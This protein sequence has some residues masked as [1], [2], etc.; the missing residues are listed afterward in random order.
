VPCLKTAEVI[1]GDIGPPRSE[2]ESMTRSL[3]E[4]IPSRKPNGCQADSLIVP[5][6]L[7]IERPNGH[8]LR[9][10]FSGNT[11]LCSAVPRGGR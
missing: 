9:F 7:P 2:S 4:A 8:L 11:A 5:Y 6:R 3:P 1:F 10:S